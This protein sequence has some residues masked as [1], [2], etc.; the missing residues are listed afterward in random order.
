MDLVLTWRAGEG[1]AAGAYEVWS[2]RGLVRFQRVLQDDGRIDV[3]GARGDRREPRREPGPARA[4]HARRGAGR[5]RRVGLLGG[6]PG[7]PL[8]RARAAELPVRL[9]ARGAAVR[10]AERA[11]SRD[12]AARLVPGPPARHA[13]R[14][15]R[16]AVACAAL[17][18]RAGRSR[19]RAR[20]G[21]ARGG[22]RAHL[23]RRARLP[24]RGRRRRQRPDRERA[25]RRARRG[26]SPGR[27]AACS[28]RFVEIGAKRPQR[29]Y[30]FLLDGM[31]QTRAGRSART[32]TP[33]RCRT[34]GGCASAPR[35]SPR[36][37]S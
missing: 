22:H 34:C 23:S 13:R 6:R 9:R 24:A 19:G 29:L 25:R 35:C 10:L 4:A 18:Q 27:T 11:G 5:S 2:A 7:A 32:A 14:A 15:P 21:G 28:R 12:L 16:A 30:L 8:R 3:R 20:A 36:A 17:V 31:H 37:R 33:P 26:T 1:D